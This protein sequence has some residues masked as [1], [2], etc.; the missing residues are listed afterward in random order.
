MYQEQMNRRNIQSASDFFLLSLIAL[1]FLAQIIFVGLYSLTTF[2]ALVSVVAVAYFL[3]GRV[4]TISTT[5]TY[6][7]ALWL[8]L[9]VVAI[10]VYRGA[11]TSADVADLILIGIFTLLVLSASDD[12]ASYEKTLVLVRGFSMFYAVTMWMQALTPGLY[13][14]IMNFVFNASVLGQVLHS[15]DGG[16]LTGLSTNAGFTAGHLCAGLFATYV[17]NRL[18]HRKKRWGFFAF[19]FISLLFTGKRAHIIFSLLSFLFL[20]L[21]SCNRKNLLKKYGEV[22][23]VVAMFVAVS[24]IFRDYLARI[25]GVARLVDSALGLLQD[26]DISN[27]RTKLRKWALETFFKYPLL[28]IGWGNAKFW[29]YGVVAFTRSMDVHNVY[30]Q[31]LCET[32]LFGFVAVCS[33]FSAFLLKSLSWRKKFF[34]SR[35]PSVDQRWGASLDYALLYQVFFL[36][37]CLTGNPLYDRSYQMMYFFSLVLVAGFGSYQGKHRLN[38]SIQFGD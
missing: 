22:L 32:G 29:S 30:V 24:V 5:I 2:I 15:R 23:I 9:P 20:Y 6:K 31:L 34:S 4:Y 21:V 28:G 13:R 7:S 1:S 18:E 37:Y 11:R 8:M 26:K 3:S 12:A 10:S 36:L 16:Y 38:P 35:V 27:G 19:L 33:V 25:P 17:L 14:A